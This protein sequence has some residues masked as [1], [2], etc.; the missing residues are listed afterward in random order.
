MVGAM[1][2]ML[3]LGAT[4]GAQSFEKL[5]SVGEAGSRGHSGGPLKARNLANIINHTKMFAA[6]SAP[7]VPADETTAYLRPADSATQVTVDFSGDGLIR[8]TV[9]ADI[10]QTAAGPDGQPRAS[11][12]SADGEEVTL[13]AKAVRNVLAAVVNNNGIAVARSLVTQGG[14]ARLIGGDE[15][16]QVATAA[17]R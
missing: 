6:L 5:D 13:T 15:T 9:D 8:F 17:L 12:L 4:T 1:T 2:L 14:V 11:R 16:T 10:V 7:S 3:G